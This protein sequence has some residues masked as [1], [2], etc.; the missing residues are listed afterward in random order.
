[1]IVFKIHLISGLIYYATHL[2]VISTELEYSNGPNTPWST[3]NI[4]GVTEITIANPSQI[5]GT[6]IGQALQAMVPGGGNSI[7][8]PAD[9]QAYRTQIE[10]AVKAKCD[11][12]TPA[13]QLCAYKYLHSKGWTL[14]G[15]SRYIDGELDA[16]I[17]KQWKEL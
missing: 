14:N 12:W 13:H 1:M 8:K 17:K 2:R 10:D 11:E 15:P 3:I 6:A 16:L 7:D 9:I 4:G 5:I